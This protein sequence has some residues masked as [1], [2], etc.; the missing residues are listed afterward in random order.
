[1]NNAIEELLVL[2]SELQQLP[3]NRVNLHTNKLVIIC[4]INKFAFAVSLRPAAQ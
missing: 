1:M 2:E 4:F 3:N